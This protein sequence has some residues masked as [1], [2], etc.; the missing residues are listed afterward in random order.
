VLMRML[1]RGTRALLGRAPPKDWAAEQN[2]AEWQGS[3]EVSDEADPDE[4]F[5]G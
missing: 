2:S 5:D 1:L 3:Q 4:E